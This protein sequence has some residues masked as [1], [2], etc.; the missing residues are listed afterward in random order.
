MGLLDNLGLS[1]LGNSLSSFGKNLS[2][3]G[4]NIDDQTG[5][6]YATRTT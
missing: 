3:L 1:G 5:I 2:N 6:T 4:T